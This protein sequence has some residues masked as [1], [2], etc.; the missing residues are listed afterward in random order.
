MDPAAASLYAFVMGVEGT[1]KED[2][3]RLITL[4][5]ASLLNRKCE[6]EAPLIMRHDCT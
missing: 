1:G 4:N 3:W 6:W 5:F 2:E